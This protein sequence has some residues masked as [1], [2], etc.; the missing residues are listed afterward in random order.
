MVTS[1]F[2]VGT[3]LYGQAANANIDP[4]TAG[5]VQYLTKPER[6][7]LRHAPLSGIV[8]KVQ[9]YHFLACLPVSHCR[10]AQNR[11]PT[12]SRSNSVCNTYRTIMG[13]IC[14]TMI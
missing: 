4:T 3:Q 11:A 10:N 8:I 14:M 6:I 12:V 13:R 2:D 7:L 1:G 5:A 9:I